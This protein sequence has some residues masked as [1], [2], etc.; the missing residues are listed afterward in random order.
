[1]FVHRRHRIAGNRAV[2][3]L[4]HEGHLV[5]VGKFGRKLL[6]RVL[7]VGEPGRVFFTHDR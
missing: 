7:L 2:G 6:R 5:V 3:L 1:M 4:G